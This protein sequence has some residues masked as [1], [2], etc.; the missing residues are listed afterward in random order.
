MITLNSV[1]ARIKAIC[2]LIDD[3]DYLYDVAC[4]H[5]KIG[6]YSMLL[7]KAKNCVFSDIS[8]VNI[9]KAKQLCSLYQIKNAQFLCLNGIPKQ[10]KE[11]CCICICGLGAQTI[12][13]ILDKA[14][15]ETDMTLILQPATKEVLLRQY[16]VNS[17]YTIEKE[18]III[19][20]GRL[21]CIFKVKKPVKTPKKCYDKVYTSFCS[22]YDEAH[23]LYIR[24]SIER[25]KK[26]Q[27]SCFYNNMQQCK[28]EQ[29]E[30]ALKVLEK[31]VSSSKK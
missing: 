4:D 30:S 2:R 10:T 17:G 21:Y 31:I 23:L 16:L 19:E 14:L 8:Q 9:E 15:L 6:V 1:G 3:V 27:N 5:G 28:V 18:D 26:L 13:D 12:I 22:N 25:L 20:K 29:I 7:G 24:K 11:N